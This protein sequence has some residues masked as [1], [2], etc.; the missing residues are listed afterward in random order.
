[1]SLINEILD[2]SKIEAGKLDVTIEDVALPDM[3]R[4]VFEIV[5]PMLETNSNRGEIVFADDA[6]TVRADAFRLKQCLLNLASNAAKFTRGGRVG[7][8]VRRV[9]GAVEIAVADSGIGMT[10]EQTAKLFQP[11]TQ[12]DS[13]IHK[14]F[15]GTGLGLVIT[16][17]LI[18]MM[19]GEVRVKSAL[20]KGSV[21]TILLPEAEADA[22]R[23]AA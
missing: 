19:G 23:E 21:F 1:L 7:F 20:G 2:L 9:G 18:E 15:G 11:F 3:L 10:P 12:A 17:R 16:K 4:D 5:R 14:T 22:E 8:R 6:H 13:Y